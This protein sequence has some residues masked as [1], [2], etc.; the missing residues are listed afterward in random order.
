MKAVL[1]TGASGFVGRTVCERLAAD[2]HAVDALDKTSLPAGL[3][4]RVREC[5][6]QDITQIFELPRSYDAVVHLAAYNVTHVGKQDAAQY[7]AVN[8]EGTR[9]VLRAARSP[10]FVF[11]STAKVYRQDSG[12]IDEDTPLDPAGPY[13]KSKAMAEAVCREEFSGETLSIFRSVNI[14]G[15][16]QACKAL[17]PVLFDQARRHEPIDIF[18]PKDSLLHMVHVQDLA[19][20]LAA[21]VQR[22][23]GQGI[24]NVPAQEAVRMDAVVQEILRLT[25]SRSRVIFSNNGQAQN[26]VFISKRVKQDFGWSAQQTV[27][28][29]LKQYGESLFLNG[30]NCPN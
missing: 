20:L 16:G 5:Y 24:Y 27:H 9:N 19:G 6:Q 12:L 23:C 25:K 4:N 26:Y 1:V 8:V 28:D 22:G 14:V 7:R 18:V 30:H 2:G 29:I 15:E 3:S 17:V 11:L 10:H 21:V 13:E